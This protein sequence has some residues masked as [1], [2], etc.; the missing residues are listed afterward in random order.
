[1]TDLRHRIG[2][3]L[4][5]AS[6]NPGK[7]REFGKL[8]APL[9]IELVGA[10]ELGLPAPEETGSSFAANA[11]IKA[12]AAARHSGLPALADDSGLMVRGLDG[13]PGIHSARWGEGDPSFR[14]ALL[15]VRDALAVRFGSF[16]AADRRAMFVCVLAIAWPDGG[17]RM[18][19]GRVEGEIVWP[20][21]GGAGF[22][23]D[24]IFVPEG[25]SRTFAEMSRAEKDRC[26]HRARAVAA[27][28]RALGGPAEP[29][30]R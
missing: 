20:P 22:G 11:A 12:H 7:L 24:P 17:E 13:A 8:L 28:L 4:V 25:D 26:S 1:M 30:E 6:H 15:R 10:A 18:F 14:S 19:E 3:K 16:E 5:L 23:Y 27:F 21:R 2:P 9:G 29:L